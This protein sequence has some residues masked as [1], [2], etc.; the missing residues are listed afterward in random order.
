M[1]IDKNDTKSMFSLAYYYQYT[2]KDYTLMKKYLLLA[3][4]KND[5]I[6]L[7][8]L[9]DYYTNND[10]LIDKLE[11]FIKYINK[12]ERK[13]IIKNINKIGKNKLNKEDKQRFINIITKFKFEEKDDLSSSIEILVETIKYKISI[14]RLHF[15]YSLEGKGFEEAKKD[16]YD[17]II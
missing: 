12:I 7:N 11:F 13:E 5:I 6:S 1:A 3:I 17:K 10:L 9:I 2:E 8:E 16:F 15:E 14:A 4:D